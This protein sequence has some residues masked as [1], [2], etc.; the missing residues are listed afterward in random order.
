MRGGRLRS[1]DFGRHDF[2]AHDESLAHAP[3]TGWLVAQGA[4]RFVFRS[5]SDLAVLEATLHGQGVALLAHAAVRSMEGLVRLEHD[6]DP[7]ALPMYV[8]Y[9]RELRNVPRVRLVIDVLVAGLREALR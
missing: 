6:G 4:K 3:Q 8:A 9:H 2:V 7:P 5:N 1:A